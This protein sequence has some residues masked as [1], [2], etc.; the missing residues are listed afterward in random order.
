MDF[1]YQ[2]ENY[3]SNK[4]HKSRK[5]IKLKQLVRQKLSEY[6]SDIKKQPQVFNSPL[7]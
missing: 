1:F 7:S 6:G 3:C 2:K 5:K 4:M